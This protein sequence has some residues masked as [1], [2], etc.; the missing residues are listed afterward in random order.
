MHSFHDFPL[1]PDLLKAIDEKGFTEPT[2]VQREAIPLALEGKDLL[3]S[4]QTGSGKTAAFILPVLHRLLEHPSPYQ[5]SRVLVVLPTREL[6]EQTLE[7][8]QQFA[9]FTEIKAALIIGGESFKDQMTALG[10]KPEIII[11]TPGRLVEH[12]ESDTFDLTNI[13]I[14]VLDEADRMLQMGFADAMKTITEHCNSERQ[15]MLF[16]AT[17]AHEKLGRIRASFNDPVTLEIDSQKEDHQNIVQQ[18]VL[19]DDRKH[20]EKLTVALIEEE[21]PGKAIVF[22]NNRIETEQISSFL[23]YKKLKVNYIH[24]ELNQ[25]L[26]KKVMTEIREDR[27]QVLVATDLA[28]RGLDIEGVDLVINFSVARSGDAY[29]HRIGRTGRGESKGKAVSL[30]SSLEWNKMASIERYLRIR[31][32]RRTIKDLKAEYT[33]PKKLKNSGKAASKKKKNKNKRTANKK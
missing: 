22:C 3:V 20:K 24:G 7:Q 10:K 18:L 1:N 23:R 32:Q 17:L 19:A 12:I 6:A 33:G 5:G 29:A 15:N 28:A 26:R 13:E 4:A 9:A 27:I 30:I 14:V 11:A 21:Q 25:S 16:S 31:L 2:P 8:L